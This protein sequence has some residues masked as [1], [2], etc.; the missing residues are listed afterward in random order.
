MK[1]T[2][3]N[4]NCVVLFERYRNNN[5]ICLSL[6]D[7]DDGEPVATATTNLPDI[8]LDEDEV[9]IKN[10]SENEGILRA[11]IDAKVVKSPERFVDAGRFPV[12]RLVK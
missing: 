12:C 5:R 1:V 9:I 8:S 6:V 10:Y 2:F 4:Y 11:L 3:L 7:E